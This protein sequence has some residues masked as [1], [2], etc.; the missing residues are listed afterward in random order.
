M[1]VV[2]FNSC[3]TFSFFSHPLFN[4]KVDEYRKVHTEASMD[5]LEY[6]SNPINAFRLT[7][8]LTTDW[9][10]VENLMLEDVGSSECKVQFKKMGQ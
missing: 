9:R 10:E 1:D 8:R 5:I 6:L 3:D 7:K 4:S 2:S